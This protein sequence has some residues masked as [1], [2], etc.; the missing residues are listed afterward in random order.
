MK[1]YT[2]MGETKL[3][4]TFINSHLRGT[5]LEISRLLSASKISTAEIR[6]HAILSSVVLN[7]FRRNLPCFVSKAA[8]ST[9]F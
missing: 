2:L 8:S 6:L 4:G 9:P 7:K 1:N 5:A 3:Q